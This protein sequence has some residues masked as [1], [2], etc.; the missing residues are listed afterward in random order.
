MFTGLLL[1]LSV[2]CKTALEIITESPDHKTLATVAG[3]FPDIVSVLSGKTQLTVF[4]PTDAAFTKLGDSLKAVTANTTL[5]A[6][7]LKYH[8]ISGTAFDPTTAP[9]LS[10]PKTAAGPVLKVAVSEGPKVTLSFGLNSSDVTASVPVDNGVVHVVDSVLIPPASVSE[11]AVAA[12]F[13]RLVAALKQASLVGTVDGL[14]NATI[15]APTDDAFIAL[16][17]YLKEKQITLT[18]EILATVLKLHVVPKVVYSTDIVTAGSLT[19]PTVAGSELKVAVVD[20]AVTIK[21]AGN[22]TPAKVA[23]A[24][25]LVSGGVVHAIDTVLLPDFTG[26]ETGANKDATKSSATTSSVSLAILAAGIVFAA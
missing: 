20:G 7:V 11:T 10:F 22:P 25:V 5:L 1:A 12:G 4:A 3:Q 15:F 24:D 26:A 18:D 8:V 23:I 2:S 13:T 16:D 14:T 17:A 19:A 21:G 6:T 9:P